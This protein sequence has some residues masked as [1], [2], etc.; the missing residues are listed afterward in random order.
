MIKKII[1][2]LLVVAV[3]VWFWKFNEKQPTI[4]NFD[5]CVE[6]GNP[7]MESYPRV[8]RTKQ[9]QSFSESIG[10][11]T[12][13]IDLIQIESPRPNTQISSPIII[14]GKAKGTWFFEGSFP[15]KLINDQGVVIGNAIATADGEWMTQDFVPFTASLTFSSSGTNKGKL[16]LEKDNPSGLPENEDFLEVPVNFSSSN[17]VSLYY[18]SKKL[19]PNGDCTQEAIVPVKR[20]LNKTQTPIQDAIKML[21]KGDLTSSEKANGLITEFPLEGFDLK[22]ANLKNGELTLEF[23]DPKMK[24]SGGSCRVSLLWSQ[25]EK[26]AAQFPEVK[27]VDFIPKDL[28][29]P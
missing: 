12:E 14:K 3:A 2:F 13:K 15:I 8:C 23:I 24:T 9:G 27:S 19:D 11:E 20:S 6:A 16:I 28:F 10:N 21:I 25:I 1:L 29:Q 5:E 7:V 4:S 26:T 17:E 22:G 18:Y